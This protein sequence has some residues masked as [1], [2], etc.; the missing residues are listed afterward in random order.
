VRD[1]GSGE[2][3]C[4]GARLCRQGCVCKGCVAVAA[5]VGCYAACRDAMHIGC[6]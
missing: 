4:M 1:T 6:I 5:L 2:R 3:G